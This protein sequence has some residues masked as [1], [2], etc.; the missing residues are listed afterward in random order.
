MHEQV[1]V[2]VAENGTKASA[3]TLAACGEGERLPH[4]HLP[5]VEV[6]LAYVR[7][8]PLRHKLLHAVPVVHN[9]A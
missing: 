9:I 5:Y 1:H 2:T 6:V 4:S 8:R 3:N 7:R